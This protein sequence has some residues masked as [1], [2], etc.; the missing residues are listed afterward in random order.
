MV[1]TVS[2]GLCVRPRLWQ[3]QGGLM[4]T[5]RTPISVE[6]KGCFCFI[7]PNISRLVGCFRPDWREWCCITQVQKRMPK[8]MWPRPDAG[9]LPTPL[10]FRFCEWLCAHTA[11]RFKSCSEECSLQD[12]SEAW[13][14]PCSP[15]HRHLLYW[16][17]RRRVAL[18]C[19][20]FEASTTL[21]VPDPFW[22]FPEVCPVPVRPALSWP[23]DLK[24]PVWC[25]SCPSRCSP[26]RR[27]PVKR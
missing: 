9:S 2:T 24:A 4:W 16:L 10:S 17:N 3:R 26:G 7:H 20:W 5:C 19:V 8:H 14:R 6:K 15:R 23:R 13:K 18:V 1:L 11:T 12:F 25:S 21:H 22:G 27:C